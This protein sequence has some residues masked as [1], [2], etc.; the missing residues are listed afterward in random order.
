M[1]LQVVGKAPLQPRSIDLIIKTTDK[2]LKDPARAATPAHHDLRSLRHLNL[3]SHPDFIELK[4]NLEAYY[5]DRNLPA[6]QQS[7]LVH[8]SQRW[9]DVLH[10]SLLDLLSELT[11][12]EDSTLQIQLLAK[13]KKWYDEKTTARPVP[14]RRVYH[15]ALKPKLMARV[16]VTKDDLGIA[17]KT[18]SISKIVTQSSSPVKSRKLTPVHKLETKP[19]YEGPKVEF[20]EAEYQRLHS[21]Y[22]A[23]REQEGRDIQS[24]SLR[25]GEDYTENLRL[26][27]RHRA[28][29]EEMSAYKT[30]QTRLLSR[31]S[32]RRPSRSILAG[33]TSVFDFRPQS[34]GSAWPVEVDR[35]PRVAEVRRKYAAMLGTDDGYEAEERSFSNSLTFYTTNKADLSFLQKTYRPMT[36]EVLKGSRRRGCYDLGSSLDQGQGRFSSTMSPDSYCRDREKH[37]N[38]TDLLDAKRRLAGF[39]IPFTMRTL[40]A[41]LIRPDDLPLDKLG[42]LPSPGKQLIENPIDMLKKSKP[43]KRR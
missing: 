33:D 13:V 15:E 1:S 26:F 37:R 20:T 4:E 36:G 18:E 7:V 5:E 41:G 17:V 10:I 39:S 24:T 40:E 28:R 14:S 11:F 31:V 29:F 27:S 2:R 19:L 32:V 30:E 8:K 35:F 22:N 9:R 25:T 38:F 21:R 3:D 43:K 42:S 34:Q 6:Q 16:E 23:Y 12:T